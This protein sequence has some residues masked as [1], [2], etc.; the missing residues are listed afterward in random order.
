MA[1]IEEIIQ[2]IQST[3]TNAPQERCFSK[4]AI[5][6]CNLVWI[7]ALLLVLLVGMASLKATDLNSER[8]IS[9]L[10]NF[11][12]ILSI[13]LSISSILFAYFTSRD[14]NNQYI[15]MGKA[16]EE[17]RAAGY[18]SIINN[19]DLLSQVE[20]IARD[21]SVLNSKYDLNAILSQYPIGTST[22]MSKDAD[23]QGISNSTSQLQKSIYSPQDSPI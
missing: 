1:K 20:S 7:I 16:L 3:K 19:S 10:S 18:Q 13:I 4:H 2:L 22:T 5:I 23:I 12:M 6:Y 15:A 11:S 17:V 21:V 14:T 9:M 8:L